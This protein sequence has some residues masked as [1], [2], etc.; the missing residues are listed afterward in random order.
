MATAQK[1]NDKKVTIAEWMYGV[2]KAPVVPEKSTRGSE[3]NQVTFKVDR[4]ATKPQ[5]K[6]A[7]EALFEVKVKAVNTIVSKGKTKIFKGRQGFRQDTKK[8]IISLEPGQ[9]I[10]TGTGV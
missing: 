10:D 6:A 5:I 8:A 3:A 2:I 7:V 1:K 9:M 4:A